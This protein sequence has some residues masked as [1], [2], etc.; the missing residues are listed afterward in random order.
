VIELVGWRPG[1]KKISLTRLL[2]RD[3]GFSLR[4]AKAA[5]D[6]LLEGQR[7][8][9]TLLPSVAPELFLE[10]ASKVGAECIE[11]HDDRQ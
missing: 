8:K 2:Q 11:V 6:S 7:V 3:C 4:I 10:Q 9:V 5:V 1:L